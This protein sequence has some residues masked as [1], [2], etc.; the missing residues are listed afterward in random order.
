MRS[1]VPDIHAYIEAQ[2]GD[3]Q[4]M[5]AHVRSL[6]RDQWPKAKEDMALEMPTYHLGG[7][8]VF[9]LAN[10]KGHI[11]FHVLERELLNAFKHDLRTRNCG[12]GCIRFRRLEQ[13]DVELLERIV[14]YVG[15]AVSGDLHL[16]PTAIEA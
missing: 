7:R 5:L 12:K 2:P 4:L 9:A 8:P 3:R 16:A 15:T 6:I 10:Q 13:A 11:T 1:T 14:K